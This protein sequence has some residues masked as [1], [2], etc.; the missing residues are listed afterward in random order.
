MLKNTKGSEVKEG[1]Y[2]LFLLDWINLRTVKHLK[3]IYSH[4]ALHF[5]PNS[6]NSC[7][8]YMHYFNIKKCALFTSHANWALLRLAGCLLILHLLHQH[9]L[10]Q[11]PAPRLPFTPERLDSTSSPS[12]HYHEGNTLSNACALN[13]ML[14]SPANTQTGGCVTVIKRCKPQQWA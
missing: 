1:I 7:T 6:Q 8:T 12:D 11:T 10:W 5:G 14:S 4:H 3:H 13:P 2:D 9:E